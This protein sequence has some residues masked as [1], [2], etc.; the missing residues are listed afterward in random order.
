MIFTA[1]VLIS[2]TVTSIEKTN[3]SKI[4]LIYPAKTPKAK[5]FKNEEL[6]C[7]IKNTVP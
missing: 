2:T 1:P 5:D 7:S 3:I 4:E 6:F